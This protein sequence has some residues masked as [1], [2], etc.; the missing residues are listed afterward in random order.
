MERS[1]QRF[2]PG[3]YEERGLHVERYRSPRFWE[4]RYHTKRMEYVMH[5]IKSTL[6]KGIFLDAGCGTG[7]Y[8]AAASSLGVDVVGIDI[9][10]TYLRRAR[11]R[12]MKAHLIQVD[13]KALPFRDNDID[14]TLCSE[15]IEHLQSMDPALNELLRV[16]RSTLIIT[17]PNY[18][19]LRR[20]L[21]KTSGSYLR[22]LDEVVGHI[23]VLPINKL[24]E[25]LNRDNWRTRL[26]RTVHA[27]PPI[28][29]DTLHIPR[30][31]TPLITVIERALNV[32]L[33]KLGNISLIVCEK[34][35]H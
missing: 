11:A 9:S 32:L 15:V 21:G 31:F 7:E 4:S 6:S 13:V 26:A 23:N 34:A 24:Y 17:T 1:S 3:F 27:T 22:K 19:L 33:P 5:I 30:I 35:H 28:I 10:L 29:G 16:T 18:G 12:C 8:L 25:K 14:V 2:S 20:V